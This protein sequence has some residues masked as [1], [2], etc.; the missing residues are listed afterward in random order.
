MNL[1]RIRN[2]LSR[3]PVCVDKPLLSRRVGRRIVDGGG[4]RRSEAIFGG[5]RRRSHVWHRQPI[6]RLGFDAGE[7]RP[8]LELLDLLAEVAVRTLR[9]FVRFECDVPGVVVRKLAGY[10]TGT[11]FAGE[12]VL[13]VEFGICI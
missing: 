13:K 1:I 9:I 5:R 6:H 8:A 4:R 7:D 2:R 11:V 12:E 3:R 10:E